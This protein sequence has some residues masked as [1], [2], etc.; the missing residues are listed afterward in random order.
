[1]T[2]FKLT[3]RQQQ[4]AS[5]HHKV[6]EDFLKSRRLSRDDFYDVVVF[7]FLRAVKEYDEREDLKQY[8]F[9]SI[10]KKRMY[11]ALGHYFTEQRRKKENMVVLSLDYPLAYES[12]LTFGDII[13]DE[14][15]N[16]CEEVC[17]KLS[18]LP[19]KNR[20]LYISQTVTVK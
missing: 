4:F 16:V 12:G 7:Q 17:E 19:R 10:A 20:L 3:V 15:T 14:R 13:A 18:R 8:S 1:M 2:D 11:S 9:N 6:L 5:K